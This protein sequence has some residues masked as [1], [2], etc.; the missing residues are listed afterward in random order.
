M[1]PEQLATIQARA[2]AATEGPWFR[3]YSDVVT[4]HPDPRDVED[5]SDD[6]RGARVCRRAAHIDKRD[7]QGIADAE[8]IAHARTDVPALVALVRE[9][10]AK[11]DRIR[12]LADTAPSFMG[13]P[14]S[15]TVAVFAI[16]AALTATEE[17]A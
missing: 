6:P 15:G 12:V 7:R 13:F 2:D 9:Q 17:A 3:E 5:G 10:A 14:D 16:R 1:T 4:A 8:F 11:L